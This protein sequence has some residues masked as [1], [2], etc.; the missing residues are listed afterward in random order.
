MV[1]VTLIVIFIIIMWPGVITET[2]ELAPSGVVPL[3]GNAQIIT[4]VYEKC[5]APLITLSPKVV[6]AV[7]NI[8]LYLLPL[9]FLVIIVGVMLH[10]KFDR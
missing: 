9:N 8:A 7:L 1:S 10:F 5:T 2:C 3:V 4:S 6:S